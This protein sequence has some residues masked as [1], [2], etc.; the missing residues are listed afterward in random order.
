LFL[1]KSG[2]HD[3]NVFSRICRRKVVCGLVLFAV[4][5]L[6]L[7]GTGPAGL[8]AGQAETVAVISDTVL[9]V[10]PAPPRRV[11]VPELPL[12]FAFPQ[13]EAFAPDMLDV[14][15]H[16]CLHADD[17]GKILALAAIACLQSFRSQLAACQG[18]GNLR[19]NLR[20]YLA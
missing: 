20:H 16:G 19:Q 4:L 11:L 12:S 1:F 15:H 9:A 2:G 14:A 7:L 8:E 6:G 5:G 18:L 13:T 3:M 10:D 17:I